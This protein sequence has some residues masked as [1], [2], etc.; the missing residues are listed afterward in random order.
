MKKPGMLLLIFVILL[1]VFNGCADKLEM[2][3]RE[4]T[5]RPVPTELAREL[6]IT[7]EN[8][9][10]IDGSTSTLGIIQII[11]KAMFGDYVTETSQYPVAAS[12][13]VPSY[14]LLID[15]AIDMAIVPYASDDVLNYAREKGITLEFHRIAAEALIFITSIENSAN[16]ITTE[17]VRSIYLDYAI[18]NW[19][20]IGG[21]D[22]KLIPICRNADSGSQSQMDNLVLQNQ[23]MHPK[24]QR[25]YIALTMDGMLEQVAFY[26][27]EGFGSLRSNCYA[28]G[29]TLYTYL[30]NVSALTG[31]EAYLKIL[32]FD[33]ITPDQ[34]SLADGTYTLTDGYYAVVKSDL[35]QDHSARILINWLQGD[36]AS[37]LESLGLIPMR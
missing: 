5:S 13:T 4:N 26:H 7:C 16:S 35:P 27:T 21:P 34:K 23:E 25:N 1:A 29:Y 22:K 11:Y 9:P 20:E 14:H 31:I 6:G 37:Q 18:K 10:A 24:I 3:S 28:L 12:K 17:Q 15:G 32:A 30:K 2:Q 36:G 33:G 8:Y 19:E